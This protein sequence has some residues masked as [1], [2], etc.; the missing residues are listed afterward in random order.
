MLFLAFRWIYMYFHKARS[1][2]HTFSITLLTIKTSRAPAVR[3]AYEYQSLCLYCSLSITNSNISP[4]SI[5]AMSCDNLKFIAIL[6]LCYLFRWK[7]V[8]EHHSKPVVT[9]F[10]SPWHHFDV[11]DKMILHLPVWRHMAALHFDSSCNF[12][13]GKKFSKS[14]IA[15][16]WIC[17]QDDP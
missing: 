3:T 1:V 8:F 15:R 4:A 16:Q 10:P 17:L 13:K 11:L 5:D 7:I 12:F 9:H 14:H 2:F 6:F